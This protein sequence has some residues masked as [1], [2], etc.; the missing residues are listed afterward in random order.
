MLSAT[1]TGVAG[2]GLSSASHTYRYDTDTAPNMGSQGQL[3]RITDPSG[4]T[5]WQY[6]SEGR[7]STKTQ[8]T[9]GLAFASQ[10]RYDNTTGLLDT[11]T[12]PSGVTVKYDY[13]AVGRPNAIS[14]DT[15]LDNLDNPQPF[16]DQIVYYPYGMVKT[17][18]LA[19]V[20][21]SPTVVRYHDR[22]LMPSQ[23]TYYT[24][25]FERRWLGYDR[26]G[27]ITRL[28][29][30]NPAD[31]KAVSE[32]TYDYDG[33]NRLTD[34]TDLGTGI[35][36]HYAYDAV[37]NRL[38]KTIVGSNPIL[39]TPEATSNRLSSVGAATYQYDSTGNL[40][41]NGSA[42]IFG[43]D[44]HNRHVYYKTTTGLEYRYLINALGQR[45]GRG[46]TALSTGGRVY[47]Y[48]ES[49]HLIGEYDKTKVRQQEHI[50]LGDL[51]VG[52]IGSGGAVY[53]VLSDHLGTPRQIIDTAKRIRWQW[54][55]SD[56]FGAN[57]TNPNPQGLGS[58]AYTMRFPGQLFD[59]ESGLFYNI[60]RSYDSNKGRY[61]QSD[62][63]GLRGGINTYAYV[64]NNPLR[65]VDPLGLEEGS[66]T[67]L[68]KRQLINDLALSYNGSTAWCFDC[69][70]DN[71][72]SG[73]NKCNKYVYDVAT[74]AGAQ[75]LIHARAPLAAEWATSSVNITNWRTLNNNETPQAGDV[76]AYR[77]SGGG[78]AYSGHT[79]IITSEFFGLWDSNSSAHK[80][81][82]SPERGQFEDN[83]KTVYRRFTG[84]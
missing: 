38:E 56:P 39:Y 75:P 70:K 13:D 35:K 65:W 60:N 77:L 53:A 67:N 63:I 66:P 25:S 23:Y 41:D 24:D 11:L 47:V 74:Q 40:K 26:I 45:T 12:Y 28:G 81:A 84:D 3:T 43:Y 61:T 58:F 1:Y 72:P 71:F 6:D 15:T 9:Y 34:F 8:T 31:G 48:D 19:N 55:N 80:Y 54:N 44:A 59:G 4:N 30:I 33:Q 49:S 37:G 52:V 22:N 21:G 42:A 32:Q 17:Y 16:I 83:D 36:Q 57:T 46:S 29:Y 76:A 14:I 18:R 50:W 69:K 10:Y 7:L 82:V 27:N 64:L 62:P 68:I 73:S 78:S 79:G 20:T 2:L 5:A 51:P